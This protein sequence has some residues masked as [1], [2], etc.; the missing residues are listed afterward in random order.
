MSRDAELNAGERPLI[1]YHDGTCGFCLWSQSKAKRWDRDERLEF[2]DYNVHGDETPF[3]REQLSS[4]MHAQTP[5]GRWHVGFFAWLE[6]LKVLPR[7]RWL[8]R[9][10]RVPPLRWLGPPLYAL[11]ANNRYR[12]SAWVLRRMGAPEMCSLDAAPDAACRVHAQRDAVV[13]EPQRPSTQPA[14]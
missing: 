8:A 12:I 9:L 1:I 11:V 5:D 3:P 2:R 7:W 4:R 13:R 6:I 10:L 14:P